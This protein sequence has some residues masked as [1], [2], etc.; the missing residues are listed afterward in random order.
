MLV[1]KLVPEVVEVS[2]MRPEYDVRQ[3]MQQGIRDLLHGQKLPGVMVVSQPDEDPLCA[4]DVETWSCL[5]KGARHV[6]STP[7][8]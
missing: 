1:A 2:I 7:P 3:L 5:A 4:V 8:T 6:D